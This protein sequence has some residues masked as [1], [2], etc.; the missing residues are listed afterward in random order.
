MLSY[1]QYL[2][3]KLYD[4]IDVDVDYIFNKYFKS[5]YRNLREGVILNFK[6]SKLNTTDLKSDWAKKAHKINPM[7]IFIGFNNGNFYQPVSHVIELSPPTTAISIIKSFNNSIYAVHEKPTLEYI[8]K[9]MD[10]G[11]RRKQWIKEFDDNR[12]KGTIRHEL[13]HWLDDTFNN[14]HIKRRVMNHDIMDGFKSTRSTYYEI[15]ATIGNV[16]EKKRSVSPELWNK[17]T[18][19]E[20][21]SS[22]ASLSHVRLTLYQVGEYKAWKKAMQKRMHREGLLGAN[23]KRT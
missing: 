10:V 6:D 5:Y 3:E 22:M 16:I 11:S 14:G 2:T 18:F 12:M 17:F 4:N 7:H 9:V 15:N 21:I 23:M 13:I 19:E 8:S 20:F 1:T